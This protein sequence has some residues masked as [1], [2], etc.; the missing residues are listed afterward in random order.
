LFFDPAGGRTP[1]RTPHPAGV[2]CLM[3]MAQPATNDPL[4]PPPAQ[5]GGH[6][7]G[8]VVVFFGEDD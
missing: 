7:L 8:V 5:V 1:K 3:A 4:G 6:F 2:T